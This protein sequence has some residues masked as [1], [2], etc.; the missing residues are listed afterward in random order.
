MVSVCLEAHPKRY[1]LL[2]FV[3]VYGIRYE[4]CSQAVDTQFP[5]F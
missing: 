5:W 3:L 2:S 4:G 1:L